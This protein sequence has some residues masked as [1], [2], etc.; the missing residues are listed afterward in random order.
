MGCS[1]LHFELLTDLSLKTTHERAMKARNR[2]VGLLVCVLLI[3]IICVMYDLREYEE[4][5]DEE[6]EY[7]ITIS[8]IVG[9]YHLVL[10]LSQYLSF[11]E[12]QFDSF[13]INEI[14]VEELEFSTNN[15][16]LVDVVGTSFG[17][18][19]SHWRGN[20][21]IYENFTITEISFHYIFTLSLYF[22]NMNPILF[23]SAN[24]MISFDVI[25]DC[26]FWRPPKHTI[27]GTLATVGLEIWIFIGLT[28]GM[29]ALAI[30]SLKL[31]NR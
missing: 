5:I 27:S 12:Y 1:K 8:H 16:R 28:M 24:V 22:E 23:L 7:S 26:T 29:I 2:V 20:F 31:S 19:P 11:P 14:I 6:Q 30:F 10:N 17:G 25:I 13:E 4:V 18:N 15:S 9:I 21:S 3:S